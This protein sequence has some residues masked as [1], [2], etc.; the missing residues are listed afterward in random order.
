[1]TKCESRAQSLCCCFLCWLWA[2]KSVARIQVFSGRKLYNS[3]CL[4]LYNSNCHK[5]YNFV[6]S[7]HAFYFS[8]KYCIQFCWCVISAAECLDIL[9][10]FSELV[11]YIHRCCCCC[12]YDWI[13]ELI[14][15]GRKNFPAQTGI[16]HWWFCWVASSSFSSFFSKDNEWQRFKLDLAMAIEHESNIQQDLLRDF[17][18][19]LHFQRNY[20]QFR[21]APKSS[22]SASMM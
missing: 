3:N 4:R 17:L 13:I 5:L 19:V 9:V 22:S 21:K 14:V 12:P 10:W 6:T 16:I 7:I 18:E 2:D 1:M 11:G 20:L 15:A 8:Q